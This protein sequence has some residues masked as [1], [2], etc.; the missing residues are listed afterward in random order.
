[1][2]RRN[3]LNLAAVCDFLCVF[4]SSP[5]SREVSVLRRKPRSDKQNTAV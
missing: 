3:I 2:R 1:M 4:C 5:S